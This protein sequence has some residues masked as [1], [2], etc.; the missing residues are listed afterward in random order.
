VCAVLLGLLLAVS[1][2]R[3]GWSPQAVRHDLPVI[4]RVHCAFADLPIL[5]IT[6]NHFGDQTGC[7]HALDSSALVMADGR[8][9][10]GRRLRAEFAGSGAALLWGS[11]QHQWG[12]TSPTV[13]S[14]RNRFRPAG[15]LP[16]GISL[17][18]LRTGGPAGRL[19]A[20]T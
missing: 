17:W 8:R 19:G 7:G 11:P 4:A 9:S 1:A 10:A 14:F 3:G 18:T 5:L 12:W 2:A 6:T 20:H 15:H 13:R 16:G